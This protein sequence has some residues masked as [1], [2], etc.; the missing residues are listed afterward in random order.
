M[1]KIVGALLALAVL[2]GA[3]VVGFQFLVNGS[4]ITGAY[5]LMDHPSTRLKVAAEQKQ[6]VVSLAGGGQDTAEAATSADCYVKA[7]G[8]LQG[9]ILTAVFLPVETETMSYSQTEADEENRKLRIVFNQDIA[10]ITD[11]DTDGY[12]GWGADFVGRYQRIS[13]P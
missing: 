9:N 6:Y 10:Q 13:I 4:N 7:R 12:C 8:E 2:S 5:T 1:K 11:A 3:L